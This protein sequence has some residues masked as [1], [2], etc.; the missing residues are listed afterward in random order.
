METI[1]DP[2]ESLRDSPKFRITLDKHESQIDLFEKTISEVLKQCSS[3]IE[4][5]KQYNR[6]KQHFLQSLVNLC[7]CFNDEPDI[8]KL[9]SRFIEPLYE[10]NKYENILNEQHNQKFQENLSTFLHSDIGTVKELKRRFQKRSDDLDLVFTRHSQIPKNKQAEWKDACNMLTATKSCFQHLT[11]D[12]VAQLTLFVSRRRHIVLDSLLALTTA[13]GT[14][15]HQAYETFEDMKDFNA[16]VANHVKS[17]K[18]EKSLSNRHHL[19]QQHETVPPL[20]RNGETIC[21][22]GYLFKR[23][24]N[25]FKSWNRRW[26]IVQNHQLSYQKR[27]N[28]EPHVMEQDLR[29]CN[30]RPVFEIDRRF[31]FEVVSPTKSHLLQ[32]ESEESCKQWLAALQAGIDAAYSSNRESDSTLTNNKR[33]SSTYLESSS[34][35]SV[36]TN[37]STN[38][39]GSIPTQTTNN[40]TI[41]TNPHISSSSANHVSSR[42]DA[43][44]IFFIAG[45]DRCADCGCNDPVWASINLGITLCIECSGVHRSLGVHVSKVRSLTL[46]HLDSEQIQVM[47]GL[48]NTVIN[49]IYLQK[50]PLLECQNADHNESNSSEDSTEFSSESLSSEHRENENLLSVSPNQSNTQLVLEEI[51]PK[52][53]R[54]KREKW[55]KAK[56]LDKLFVNKKI[57]IDTTKDQNNM[58]NMEFNYTSNFQSQ[59]LQ[60]IEQ[61]NC[62]ENSNQIDLSGQYFNLLL[63]EASALNDLK[64]MAYALAAGASINWQNY[65]DHNRTPLF[66]AVS[67]GTMTTSEYLLLN[68]AKCNIQDDNGCTPLHHATRN[69]NT[70]QVC[71]LLKRG[72]DPSITNQSDEDALS[73]AL[74]KACADIVT[75][76]RLK[77]LKDEMRNDELGSQSDDTFNEVVRDF[78]RYQ[79]MS[80]S[81][82]KQ[83]EDR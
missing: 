40:T 37:T 7:H 72:A 20:I 13:H 35:D 24:T 55:I 46:D 11:L 59:I 58:F 70:G 17:T 53:D 1:V 27:S 6:I 49:K 18:L 21:I 52:S 67:K 29:L 4:I 32:A 16:E 50:W 43:A 14:H 78:S 74:D 34:L 80:E 12:Y 73:I 63:Y 68:G 39:N 45:N 57:N 54:N 3:M 44:K 83:N 82:L 48:G 51:N 64:T 23:T 77:K 60:F 5:G 69:S 2:A 47:L 41:Y 38:S 65:Y 79:I 25:A 56:Y 9:I 61:Q 10:I 30:A 22:E 71:L 62:N 15:F 75:V 31:C 28:E 81:S 26:F 76:L 19:V 8:S 42:S 66:Q 33:N 36:C